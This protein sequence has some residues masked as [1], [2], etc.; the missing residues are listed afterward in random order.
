[1]QL[2]LQNS[3]LLQWILMR[4]IK[5]K[6][7]YLRPLNMPQKLQTQPLVV[8]RVLNYPRNIRYRHPVVI[9]KFHVA[10]RGLERCKLVV[11]YLRKG[12][13]AG[14][15]K[16]WFP[17]VR[18]THQ[19]DIRQRFQLKV[20]YP[21]LTLPT[22]PVFLRHIRMVLVSLARLPALRQQTALLVLV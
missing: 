16:C 13:R 21:R 15:K 3:V 10:H 1:M 12:S 20:Y 2:I 18:Q 5:H 17:D 7:K 4:D 8:M 6:N 11:G 19:S 9:H 14:C 22:N